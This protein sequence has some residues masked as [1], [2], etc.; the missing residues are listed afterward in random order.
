VSANATSLGDAVHPGLGENEPQPSPAKSK[1][2]RRSERNDASSEEARRMD[3]PIHPPG[4][5][6]EVVLEA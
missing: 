5:R 3:D 2:A 4:S 1:V 6:S